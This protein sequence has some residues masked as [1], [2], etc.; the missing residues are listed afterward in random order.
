[1]KALGAIP[2]LFPAMGSHGGGDAEAQKEILRDYG[3]TEEAMGAPIRASMEVTR[4]G[5]TE[6]GIPVQI[7]RHAAGADHIIVVNRVKPHTEFNGEIESGLIK[8]MVIGMGKHRGAI[9]AHE[10]AVKKGYERTLVEIG[11]TILRKAPV[12]LGLAILENGYGDTARV[13]AVAPE[14]F[15]ETEKR[16]LKEV[17]TTKP[18][19]PFDVMDVLVLD[20]I[21]KEVSGAGMDT[22]VVG[23]IMN[24]YEAELTHP[25]ITRI[26]VR[27]LSAKTHGNA[28]G[29]GLADFIHRR[30]IDKIDRHAT[31]VNCV[32]SVAPEKARIPILCE[33]DREAIDQALATSGPVTPESVRLVWIRNTMALGE[34][35][36]SEGLLEEARKKAGVEVIGEARELSF[37]SLGGL[38]NPW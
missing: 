38:V 32:T 27:D 23:R 3:I 15:L 18:K 20:E 7:D 11:L 29:I 30:I 5:E 24:I 8:M 31:N 36:V 9:V 1:V 37:D 26:V 10:Y 6:S 22:K 4:I 21:G 17:R 35:F 2:F 33:T 34:M 16:L 13:A 14:D 25:K 19:L 12:V 28:V